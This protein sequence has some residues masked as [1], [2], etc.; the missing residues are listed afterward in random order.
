MNAD[1]RSAWTAWRGV[2]LNGSGPPERVSTRENW[3][4]R[5]SKEMYRKSYCLKGF[6]DT[7]SLWSKPH[8]WPF[9]EE[10]TGSLFNWAWQ[11]SFDSRMACF[12]QA[13][14]KALG[15]ASTLLVLHI[16]RCLHFVG[17]TLPA[18]QIECPT[19]SSLGQ[20]AGLFCLFERGAP[21]S[22]GHAVACPKPHLVAC[23]RK[24]KKG[25]ARG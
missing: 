25:A 2:Q 11:S 13:P 7:F 15:V 1:L 16:P 4:I 14:F 10:R 20:A 22:A 23:K 6:K 18:V 17:L 3:G 9:L 19:S 8:A 5:Q 21:G 24:R 12:G